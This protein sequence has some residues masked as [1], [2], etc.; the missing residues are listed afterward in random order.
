MLHADPARA[1]AITD[2]AKIE[3]FPD[4]RVSIGGCLLEAGGGTLDARLE[5]QLRQL[6][7]TLTRA[8]GAQGELP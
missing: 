3:I 8:R 5:V 1:R 7:D 2:D 4:E 6:L